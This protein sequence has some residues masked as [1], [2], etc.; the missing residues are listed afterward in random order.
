MINSL[1]EIVMALIL[2]VWQ[3]DVLSIFVAIELR[4]SLLT[5]IRSVD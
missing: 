4:K 5:V 1:E 3:C 2:P